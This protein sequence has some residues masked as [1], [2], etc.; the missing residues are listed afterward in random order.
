[1]PVA[2]RGQSLSGN[3]LKRRWIPV[4]SATDLERPP[5]DSLDARTL[6]GPIKSR[7]FLMS[8]YRYAADPSEVSRFT[9]TAADI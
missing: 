5:E 3:E 7:W 1:M 2:A 4:H 9:Q 6:L 8:V